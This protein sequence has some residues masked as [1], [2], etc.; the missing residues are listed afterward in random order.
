MSYIEDRLAAS[1][2][3]DVINGTS[4]EKNI[5]K[6]QITEA[7]RELRLLR[8]QVLSL[9]DTS[10]EDK[11]NE[12]DKDTDTFW[13]EAIEALASLLADGYQICYDIDDGEAKFYLGD[14]VGNP[15][16]TGDD[17]LSSLVYQVGVM[18]A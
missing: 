5:L 12:F 13:R 7:I 3:F 11:V 9:I 18:N 6:K 2:K 4:E 8:S 16:I 1:L 14:R 17:S 10:R 15:I